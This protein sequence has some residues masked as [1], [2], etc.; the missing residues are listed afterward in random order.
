MEYVV[1]FTPFYEGT[2]KNLYITDDPYVLMMRSTEI[3]SDENGKRMNTIPG[4]ALANSLISSLL[5][6]R[7]EEQGIPTHIVMQGRNP[8]SKFVRKAEMIQLKVIF[9]NR[10]A[11]NFCKRYGVKNGSALKGPVIEFLYKNDKLNNPF[12]CD[13]AAIAL[14][15]VDEEDVWKI[16]KFTKKINMIAMKFF[17]E[18]GLILIDFKVEYGKDYETGKLMLCDE[19][20][21]DTCRLWYKKENSW[22]KDI[23]GKSHTESASEKPATV[24]Q[25]MVQKLKKLYPEEVN[26]ILGKYQE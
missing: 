8:F 15:I 9:R 2:T 19:L 11:G 21:L 7:F 5:Y 6:N 20:S 25:K 22:D 14:G 12:I 26:E 1:N 23:D 4:K 16:E 18:L 10:A 3:V 13:Y 24:Y 17:D